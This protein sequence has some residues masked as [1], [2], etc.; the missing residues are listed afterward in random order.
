MGL[1]VRGPGV[2]TEKGLSAATEEI[3]GGAGLKGG[4]AI[5]LRTKG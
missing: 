3:H 2:G 4:N 1:D 5:V